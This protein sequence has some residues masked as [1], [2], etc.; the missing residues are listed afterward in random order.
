MFVLIESQMN[1]LEWIYV[2]RFVLM[3]AS[4]NERFQVVVWEK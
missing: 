1:L 2:I 4:L 3:F